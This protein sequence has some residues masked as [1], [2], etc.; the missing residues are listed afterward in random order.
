VFSNRRHILSITLPA[1]CADDKSMKNIFHELSRRYGGG[2]GETADELTQYI[3]YSEWQRELLSGEDGES[4]KAYW[5]SQGLPDPSAISLPGQQ[6]EVISETFRPA[7][8]RQPIPGDVLS[9]IQEV[10]GQYDSALPIFLQVCWHALIWRLTGRSEF[11]IGAEFSGREYEELEG[12]MGAFARWVPI[13]LRFDE[14]SKFKHALAQTEKALLETL[15][16]QE[17]FSREYMLDAKGEPADFAI[18]FEYHET[19]SEVREGNLS[20]SL[21]RLY[22]CIDRF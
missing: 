2:A 21:F 7:A 15:E 19:P 16:W 9:N 14:T 10:C 18:G 17:Y 22:S 6:E 8:F 11:V 3:H 12:A 13:H 20:F 5:I 4:G 1:L